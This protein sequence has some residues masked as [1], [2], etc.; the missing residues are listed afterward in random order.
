MLR[1]LQTQVQRRL[2]VTHQHRRHRPFITS[3]HP[4]DIHPHAALT[5]QHTHRLFS[6]QVLARSLSYYL[7]TCRVVCL[8]ASSLKPKFHYANFAAKIT[9]FV[10]YTNHESLRQI[11][12]PTFMICVTDFRDLC[13]RA[14]SLTFLVHCNGLNSI[15]ATQTGLW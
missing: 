2:L 3:H 15:R 11:L 12:S 5:I 14:L 8:I 9:N 4:V 1:W 7:I 6:F 13:S 10:I